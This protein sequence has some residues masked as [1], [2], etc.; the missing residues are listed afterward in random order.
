MTLFMADY[1]RS[2][3]GDCRKRGVMRNFLVESETC[4]PAPRKVHAQFL[5]ELALAADTV[6]I[7]NQQ[8]PQQ[9]FWVDRRTTSFAIAVLQLLVQEAEVDMLINQPQQMIL[10][11][12]I[13]QLEVVE[14]GFRAH[15]LTH[16]EPSPCAPGH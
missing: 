10:W 16:H 1:T 9:Q 11:N 5:G 2:A 15:V 14:Q 4:E 7:T 8:N 3:R 13:F 6:Q 12:L